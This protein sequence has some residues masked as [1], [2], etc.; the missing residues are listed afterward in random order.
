MQIYKRYI[1]LSLLVPFCVVTITLT[2]IIWLSQSLRFID[3]IVNK[4]L[5]V[6]TFLYLTLLLI[7]SLFIVILPFALFLSVIFIYNKL[8]SDSELLVLKSAGISRIG[9]ATPAI[10]VA[11]LA[12]IL[13][14][15]ISLYVMPISAR[16]FKN[17]QNLIRNN[18][19]ST[20]LQE[21]VFSTPINGLT[22]Y[23][24]SRDNEGTLHGILVDDARNQDKRMTLMAQEGILQQTPSGPRFMLINGNRQEVNT[25]N[26]NLSTL[27]FDSYPLDLSF[28]TRAPNK[29]VLTTEERYINELLQPVETNEKERNIMI[30][31]GH[32]R[33][34]WPL[35]SLTL[36]L[37]AVAILFS[38][39]LNR[40]GQW[41]RI[42]AATLF[43][44][45]FIVIDLIL[46]NIISARP[47][48]SFM[49]YA[50]TILPGILCIY[51]LNSSVNISP[52]FHK[53]LRLRKIRKPV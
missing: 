47:A 53:L 27:Y 52:N 43:A 25:E 28:Y 41:K 35:F 4:G 18:Y 20:L 40:R 49:F 6:S 3:L 21:G 19:A 7:P 33:L 14:Y 44:M 10:F 34:T 11:V 42:F 16:E 17:L 8:M 39:Q 15:I 26:G 12:T 13:N 37:V 45:L 2:S 1:V 32:H 50:N 29:R 9:I 48:L 24:E 46:K 22:V 23:I 36:T 30:S 31:E 5:E 38:G 51:I